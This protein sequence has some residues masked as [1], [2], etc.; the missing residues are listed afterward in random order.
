MKD[1]LSGVPLPKGSGLDKKKAEDTSDVAEVCELKQ[2][3]ED[4]RNTDHRG[5]ASG[6]HH[7]SD[8]EE[9]DEGHGH[10]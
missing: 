8:E 5:G 3:S 7:D 4:H 9:D 2:F 1:A 10:G 6:G